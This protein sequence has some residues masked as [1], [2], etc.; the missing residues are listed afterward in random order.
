MVLLVSDSYSFSGL[1]E[2]SVTSGSFFT[3]VP[4]AAL[5]LQSLL[6]PLSLHP[7]LLLLLEASLD[8]GLSTTWATSHDSTVGNLSPSSYSSLPWTWTT[9]QGIFWEFYFPLEF[10]RGQPSSC[11]WPHSLLSAWSGQWRGSSSPSLCTTHHL[12]PRGALHYV[13]KGGWSHPCSG[14]VPGG[15][16]P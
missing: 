13:S 8:S 6:L 9:I 12:L 11:Q 15:Q 14:G 10:M 16:V 7:C 3:A 4:P 1:S 2:S 5:P